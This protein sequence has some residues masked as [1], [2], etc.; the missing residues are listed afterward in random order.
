MCAVNRLSNSCMAWPLSGRSKLFSESVGTDND[1]NTLS[2]SAGEANWNNKFVSQFISDSAGVDTSE[3]SSPKIS[4]RPVNQ[5]VN[6]DQFMPHVTVQ[7]E[8]WNLTSAV[9][10]KIALT[11]LIVFNWRLCI[12]LHV[13]TFNN[14][15]IMWLV[16]PFDVRMMNCKI[17]LNHGL[18]QVT[19]GLR[20][21]PKFYLNRRSVNLLTNPLRPQWDQCPRNVCYM[22]NDCF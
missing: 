16:P 2:S 3:S 15:R 8:S 20:I 11:L 21:K 19:P 1:I 9:V 13:H 17:T 10:L 14:F 4:T 12:R 22:R 18:D 5:S 7:F 6:L